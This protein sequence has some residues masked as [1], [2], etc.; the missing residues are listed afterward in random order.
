MAS[1]FG[2]TRTFTHLIPEGEF[3]SSGQFYYLPIH[4]S[5]RLSECLRRR[6]LG[7]FLKPG[8]ITL[9]FAETLLC[10]RHSGSSVDNSVR[11]DGGD[12]KAQQALAQYVA[13]A[14]L[15]LQKLSYDRPGGKVT[16]HTAYNPYFTQNTT[17]W[18]ALNFIAQLTQ[19]IPRAAAVA[20]TA[21]AL[22]S[23]KRWFAT[24]RHG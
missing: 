8:L 15:A 12:H 23:G 11:L 3:D 16:Y 20:A 10:W 17:L 2:S 14:P 13:R 21:R 1:R 9:Q 7:L 22:T 6:T 4:D 18:C 5:A 19:F 24:R